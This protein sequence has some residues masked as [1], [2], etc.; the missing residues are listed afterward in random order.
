[1]PG[2]PLLLSI[3]E[4]G[5]YPD[6]APLY[7]RLGFEVEQVTSMRKALALLKKRSPQVVV[8]EFNFQSDFRDRSSSLESLLATL[9]SRAPDA[10]MVVFY[11]EE[12]EG[13][14]RERLA[15]RWP[16]HA[17][18]PFPVDETRLEAAIVSAGGAHD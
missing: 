14:F 7:R 4:L 2:N 16:I 12:Y 3:V 5:G 18:L 10:R 17:A 1:M 8:A 15:S 6:Y 11:E 9:Q 13:P